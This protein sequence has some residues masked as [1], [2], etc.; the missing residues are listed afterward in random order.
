MRS[1]PT[2]ERPKKLKPILSIEE[3]I[4]VLS[5]IKYVDDIK[6]YTYEKELIEL[7]KSGKFNVRFLGDD[8]VGKLYTGKELN[9]DVKI[10]VIGILLSHY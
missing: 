10:L 9:I 6:V 8:Y 7:L 1:D 5:S 4:E 3:R 2:I